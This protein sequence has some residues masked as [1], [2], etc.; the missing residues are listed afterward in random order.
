[1]KRRHF[2]ETGLA[3]GAS[4]A[5]PAFAQTK[6]GYPTQTIKMIVAFGPGGS[7]DVTARIITAKMYELLG[8]RV[9]SEN[10]P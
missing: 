2:I 6:A 10:K 7:T 1:M 5:L 3:L 4:I 9:V 8:Q